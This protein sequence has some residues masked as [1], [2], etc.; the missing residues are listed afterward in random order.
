[1]EREGADRVFTASCGGCRA[2]LLYS[3]GLASSIYMVRIRKGARSKFGV[4]EAR[5][6]VGLVQA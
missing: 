3:A 5:E 4:M 6:T 1:M 2:A